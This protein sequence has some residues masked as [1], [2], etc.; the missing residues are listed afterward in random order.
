MKRLLLRFLAIA[1]VFLFAARPGLAQSTYTY[2]LLGYDYVET[3]T[4]LIQ[5][6]DG[7]L[8]GVGQD[9]TSDGGQVYNSPLASTANANSVYVFSDSTD[10]GLPIGGV[11]QA[12]DAN[13]TLYGTT[14]L[15]GND[16]VGVFY[17][18]TGLSPTAR[19]TETTLHSFS[20][21]D[22]GAPQGTPII[23]GAGIL[24][25]TARD[26]GQNGAGLLFKYDTV[27]GTFAPLYE[28]GQMAHCADGAGPYSGP[29]QGSD[30]NLYGATQGGGIGCVGGGL[31]SLYKIST[32]GS[33]IW[34]YT[35]CTQSGCPDGTIPSKYGALVEYSDGNFYGLTAGYG[36]HG[37]GTIFMITPS[38]VL[39]TLY[40]FNP[41]NG[42]DGGVP[43]DGLVVGS[44][45]NLYGTTEQYGAGGYGTVFRFAPGTRTMTTL[46]AFTYANYDGNP[47]AG[48][49]Q[50]SDGNFYGTTSGF[51]EDGGFIYEISVSPPLPAPVQLSFGSSTVGANTP[52][53]LNWQVLNAFSL[54]LQNC[55]ASVQGSSAGAG[56]W[57]GLQTGT[58]SAGTKLF[59]GSASITPTAAGT[60]TYALTCGGQESGFA[61]LTVTPSS[62]KLTPTVALNATPNPAT[63]GQTVAIKATASGSGATPTGTVVF[64]YGT[65]PLASLTL[66]GGAATLSPSTKGLPPGAY[67]LTASYSGDSN[68]SA[69][70]SAGYT[71][72]LIKPAPTVALSASPNPAMVG[73][74][75]TIRA[76]ATGSGATPTG[77]M[78]FVY[79]TLTLATLPLTAGSVSISPSTVGL[80]PGTYD[81]VAEYSGDSNY[82]A[83][84]SPSY[85]I[86][87]GKASTITAFTPVPNPV[88]PPAAC[89]LQATVTRASGGGTP[90]GSVAF[91]VDGSVLA[92]A[93]LDGSGVASVIASTAGVPAGGYPIVATYSGDASDNGS[94]SSPVVVT[95]Q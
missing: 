83:A 61:T 47:Y 80:P 66:S 24:Y 67:V 59:T 18:V 76:T 92:V 51:Q 1:A 42:T 13:G 40:S 78:S 39:T 44:D 2:A 6:R 26:G 88:T 12:P 73:Q 17:S 54:T 50:G 38:G 4:P 19:G 70:A 11:V 53:T 9:E 43:L 75:V 94:Q 95:V 81:L 74:S 46:Y 23:D 37:A 85:P 71:I 87:L 14:G 64:L 57:S 34:Q 68:Y 30:G 69:A 60:Y 49:V 48:L 62:G 79:G 20:G 52:V 25:G 22:G 89:T 36:A 3:V 35:F 65:I 8:Y 41:D 31:G 91:S 33:L 93:V 45:G 5:A 55:V 16:N 29:V 28:F 63:V 7:L 82:A 84:D 77:T 21:G 72:T 10:G 90:A 56:T 32:S 86:T 27:H 15:G 58:Y